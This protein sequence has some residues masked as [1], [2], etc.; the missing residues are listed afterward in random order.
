MD[1]I[2][3]LLED[4]FFAAIAAIGFS[5]ISNPPRNSYKWCAAIAAVG[6]MVRYVLMHNSAMQVHIIMASFVAALAV[7]TLAV[8]F[9]RKAQ[10]PAESFAFP[11]LL[12]MIPGMYAYRTVEA[13]LL[14]L[15]NSGEASSKHYL[16]LLN[17][18]GLTCIFIVLSMVI[19]ITLPIFMFK[20]I[21]FQAT[22]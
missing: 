5:C 9:S 12:P 10:C 17:Y 1:Y 16:Y 3:T 14:F 8:S 6:H 4:G 15:G 19:G 13:L 21:S 20:K 7:G 18:N 11:A 2:L 22:R